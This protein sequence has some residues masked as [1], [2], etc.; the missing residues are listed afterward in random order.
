MS[1]LNEIL[2]FRAGLLANFSVATAATGFLGPIAALGFSED[3]DSM[4]KG[5]L[6]FIVVTYILVAIAMA[7]G[8]EL[9]MN[10]MSDD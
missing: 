10:Q 9:I 8:S 5:Y 1:Q 2:K 4:T 3:P 6:G 7:V